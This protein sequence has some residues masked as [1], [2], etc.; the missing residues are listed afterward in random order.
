MDIY[1]PY[2]NIVYSNVTG[3]SR[4][5]PDIH[6]DFI[7]W[8]LF[9]RYW[10]FVRGIHR[11]PVN[12][13]HKGQSRGALMFSLICVWINGWVN[14]HEAGDLRRY[15]GHYDVIVMQ[16]V[17][18][19]RS[20]HCLVLNQ[21]SSLYHIVLSQR[22]EVRFTCQ[23]TF[24]TVGNRQD[25]LLCDTYVPAKSD[26]HKKYV[27]PCGLVTSYDGKELGQHLPR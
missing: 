6:D 19:T 18:S 7:K 2:Q 9:P 27:T 10:P 1:I 3:W 13:P 14:N 17:N 12:C 22:F 24:W 16:A 20:S 8:K 5:V 25:F 21:I 15:R 26:L 11:S 23:M 4:S